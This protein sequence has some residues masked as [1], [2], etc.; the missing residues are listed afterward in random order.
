MKSCK[1]LRELMCFLICYILVLTALPVQAVAASSPDDTVVNNGSLLVKE[2]DWLYYRNS[3]DGGSIYKIKTDGTQNTKINDISSCNI[4]IN[5]DWIYFKSLSP[6]KYYEMYR[7]KKDE[8]SQPQ[9]LGFTSDSDKEKF[10][11]DYIY[12]RPYSRDILYNSDDTLR[13]IKIDGTE[14]KSLARGASYDGLGISGDYIYY[15][16]VSDSSNNY[17]ELFFKC[18]LDGSDETQIFTDIKDGYIIKVT[19]NWIYIREDDDVASG[20]YS[21]YRIKLDG[22]EKKQIYDGNGSSDNISI[23]NDDWI[24]NYKENCFQKIDGSKVINE[25][26][27]VFDRYNNA[28]NIIDGWIYYHKIDGGFYALKTDGTQKLKIYNSSSG[29]YDRHLFSCIND[30]NYIYYIDD[31]NYGEKF[32][33]KFDINSGTSQKL[34]PEENIQKVS[35]DKKW[36]IEFTKEFDPNTIN[37]KNILVTDG[38]NS[39][40]KLSIVPNTDGKSITIS[41]DEKT[42]WDNNPNWDSIIYDSHCGGRG[43]K[44]IYNIKITQNVK[45]KDGKNLRRYVVKKFETTK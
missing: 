42:S 22:S 20:K 27:V 38:D 25:S 28:I 41:K 31:N 33:Y 17:E 19:D 43:G 3:S 40:V 32:L 36:T 5:G 6:D 8:S 18:K 44:Q 4:N 1:V 21:I 13:R 29:G 9:D 12:Y 11:G 39:P 23:L 15:N 24:Y 16:K 34:T 30:G 7:M 26:D 35:A 10:I 37:D 45:D 14:D 2:G